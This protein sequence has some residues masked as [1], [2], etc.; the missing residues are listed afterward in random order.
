MLIS[1][2]IRR[3]RD[4]QTLNRQM[5][6]LVMKGIADDSI[7]DAQI[8][9]FAMAVYLNGMNRDEAIA[10]TESI[11]DSGQ[12]MRW[13]D[14]DLQGPVLDKHSTGGVG[15]LTSLV[16]G[17]WVAACGGHVPMVSGRGL[18]HTGGTLDKLESIPGYD[19]TPPDATFRQLVQDVGIAI[20]G[21]TGSLAPADKRLY[22][23]RDVTAT[24]E[25]IP[26]IV[27]SILGKKLACGLKTLVMDVKV[28]SGAFMPTPEASRELAEAIVAIGCGAG[29]TTSVLLTDMN[30]PLA[31]CAGNALEIQEAL[32]LLRG[33]GRNQERGDGRDSRLYTVIRSLAAEMLIQS[34]L[35][36]SAEDAD[37]RLDRALDSGEAL[38]RFSR[39]VHGLGGPADLAERADHYLAAAPVEIDLTATDA[40]TLNAIDTRELGLAVVE[41][42]GGRRNAGDAIDHRVGLS[43]IAALGQAVEPGQPLLRIH[44]ASRADVEAASHRLRR[45]VTLSDAPTEAPPLVHAALRQQDLSGPRKSEETQ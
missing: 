18:G 42:G 41:L 29:T 14:L 32:R 30:Q 40:G 19:V 39:M 5:L 44:G 20:I 15:D 38:E 34:G 27:A 4:G 7:G 25:S 11:R 12:V 1:E 17:P 43:Q 9:A 22:G 28:G 26:L 10:L 6:D 33:D 3:K 23:V 37:R 21:Q 35:A 36:A 45:A 2:I 24:V 8:G 16:L 31:D 13:D